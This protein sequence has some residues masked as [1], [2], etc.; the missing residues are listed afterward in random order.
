[1]TT[2]AAK[3]HIIEAAIFAHG[4]PIHRAHVSPSVFRALVGGARVKGAC[5]HG[6]EVLPDEALEDEDVRFD[7]AESA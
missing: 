5:F 4:R 6:I 2:E 1:M 3:R 7:I